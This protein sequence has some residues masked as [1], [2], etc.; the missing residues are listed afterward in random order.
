[1]FRPALLLIAALPLAACNDGPGTSITIDAKGD[2]QEN[3]SFGSDAN[4]QM[5]IKVPGFEGA[6]KLPPIKIDAKDFD[7]NGLH[8]Y[9]DSTI[10]DLQVAAQERTGGRDT[11]KVAVAFDAPA[12]LPTVQAWFRDNLA[13]QGFKAEA[14]GNGF[15]GK[16]K[17]GEA[18]SLD[19]QADGEGKTR[20]RMEAGS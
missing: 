8:L 10:R 16:T 9:P 19:L 2:G 20:G 11:G 4:G 14:K 5:S 17:D 3:V 12:A 15:A 1:M 13:K 7:V 18:F 6:L